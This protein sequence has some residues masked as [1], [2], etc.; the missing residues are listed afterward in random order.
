MK[1]ALT[2]TEIEDVLRA[3]P[4][5][6]LKDGKL[7]REWTFRDFPE[8][9]AFVNRIA[10][11]AEEANHHPDID[12]RYN[13]VLLSLISHDAGGITERDATMAARITAELASHATSN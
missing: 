7:V 6:N 8:A 11:I 9:V 10:A 12:I 2:S 4:E 13:R 3:H 1:K 5:W